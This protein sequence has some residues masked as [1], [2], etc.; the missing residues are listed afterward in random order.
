MWGIGRDVVST[1]DGTT[2]YLLSQSFTFKGSHDS[3]TF[4][5]VIHTV[6]GGRTEVS[7]SG[8]G[9][10]TGQRCA[11]RGDRT[12]SSLDCPRATVGREQRRHLLAP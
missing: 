5:P 9:A 10:E 12:G 3:G 7:K 2:W 6:T 11:G 4:M 8:Q 1:E